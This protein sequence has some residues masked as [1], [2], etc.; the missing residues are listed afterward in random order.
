MKKGSHIVGRDARGQTPCEAK[1]DLISEMNKLDAAIIGKLPVGVYSVNW[2]D[3]P[4][5][6]SMEPDGR[7]SG[8]KFELEENRHMCIINDFIKYVTKI[9]FRVRE[10]KDAP[11]SKWELG[12]TIDALTRE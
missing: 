7:I 12:Y 4:E 2:K 8:I 1:P 5:V 3:A 9:Y 11:W 10:N 6:T